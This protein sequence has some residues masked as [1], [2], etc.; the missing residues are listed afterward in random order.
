MRI[1]DPQ[2]SAPS[3]PTSETDK[4]PVNTEGDPVANDPTAEGDIQKKYSSD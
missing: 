2:S 4:T 3:A 1:P